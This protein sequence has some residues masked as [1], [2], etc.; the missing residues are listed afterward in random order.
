VFATVF[1][2]DDFGFRFIGGRVPEVGY[3]HSVTDAASGL[4]ITDACV[5]ATLSQPSLIVV[6]F[7]R[8][9]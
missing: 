3:L 9:C 7:A 6:M 5:V 1:P 8:R 2:I 4:V